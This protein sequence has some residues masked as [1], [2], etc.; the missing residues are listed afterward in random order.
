MPFIKNRIGIKN[1]K[2]I[3]IVTTWERVGLLRW[4][5][6]YRVVNIPSRRMAKSM[7]LNDFELKFHD[8][9]AR[10]KELI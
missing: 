10:E 1:P 2:S 5:I 6:L 8:P 3:G 4:M 7:L 9:I